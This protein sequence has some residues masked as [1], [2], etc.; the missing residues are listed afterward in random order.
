MNIEEGIRG[1]SG[2]E[3]TK[4]RSDEGNGVGGVDEAVVELRG[5]TFA[6][7]GAREPAVQDITLHVGAGERIGILGPNGGGKTTLIKLVLGLLAPGSETR[8]GT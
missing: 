6:Y 5:V 2:D 8:L 1:E 4:R 3:A 7:P